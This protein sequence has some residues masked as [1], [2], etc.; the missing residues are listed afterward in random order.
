MIS[1]PIKSRRVRKTLRAAHKHRELDDWTR[2][3]KARGE[4]LRPDQRLPS[5]EAR[6]DLPVDDLLTPRR[7]YAPGEETG[8]SSLRG[9]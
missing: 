1:L 5:A 2:T 6:D 3:V 4:L 8:A 7:C 9:S